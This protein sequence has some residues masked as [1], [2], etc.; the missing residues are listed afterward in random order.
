MSVRVK[1]FNPFYV[2]LLIAGVVFTI[3]ACAYGTM[4]VKMMRPSDLETVERDSGLLPWLD[5]HG[6]RLLLVEIAALGL[7]TVA[8]I[9]TDPFWERRA[10]MRSDRRESAS[11]NEGHGRPAEP[12]LR[13]AHSDPSEP[14]IPDMQ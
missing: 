4:A 7:L 14:V 6:P 8:A 12:K 9:G 11:T 3:T 2:L 13:E 5:E 1:P 10:A